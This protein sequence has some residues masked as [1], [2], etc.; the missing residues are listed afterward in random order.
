MSQILYIRKSSVEHMY[1]ETTTSRL[2]Y[3][4]LSNA[5]ELV[6]DLGFWDLGFDILKLFWWKVW[7]SPYPSEWNLRTSED[8]IFMESG[9]VIVLQNCL[10]CQG[11]RGG[12]NK[13]DDFL[14]SKCKAAMWDEGYTSSDTPWWLA[15]RCPFRICQITHIFGSWG[16]NA[17][18]LPAMQ[19]LC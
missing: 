17:P 6:F 2:H 1:H 3:P 5:A 16:K 18:E 11:S 19:I 14:F 8:N 15:S 10:G 12:I 4:S 13:T 9:A 7:N